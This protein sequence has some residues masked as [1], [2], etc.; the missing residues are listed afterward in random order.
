MSPPPKEFQVGE[1]LEQEDLQLEVLAG[2][3]GLERVVEQASVQKPGLSLAGHLESLHPERIQVVGFS[4]IS[5]L[6]SLE[7]HMVWRRL[8][9]LC[10]QEIPCIIATRGLDLPESLFTVCRDMQIPL[11]R[12]PLSSADLID[13]LK[14]VLWSRLSPKT[15]MHGVLVDVFGV[16]ILLFGKSGIGKSETA[17]E[18]VINGHRLVADDIV[19]VSRREGRILLGSGPDIIK[20]HMEIRGLGILNIK[21]L[22]GVSAVRDR[23]KIEVVAELVKWNSEEE[24]DRLGVD[25]LTHTIL[26]VQIPLIRLPVQPGRNI[27]AIVEVAARNQLLKIKGHHSA[28]EFQDRLIKAISGG[29]EAPIVDGEVE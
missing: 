25:D 16:G 6:E 10:E 22:F 3:S 2:R 28:R 9:E 19:E 5:Y 20:H 14:A 1:L 11:L 8:R 13:G 26:G 17:M 24:Y 7:E 29:K 23:K 27:A 15:T 18:L 12:T 4:E 21:D